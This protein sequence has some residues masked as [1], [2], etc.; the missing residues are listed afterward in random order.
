MCALTSL[1]LGLGLTTTACYIFLAILVGPALEKL[2]LNKMAVHMFIFYWGMLSSITPPVAIA[3][4]TAAGI[5]KT[6]LWETGI[7]AVRIALILF[8]IPFVFVYN[9]GLLGLG[10]P[11]QIVIVFCTTAAGATAL[12][13]AIIGYWRAHVPLWLRFFFAA[14]AI[15]LIIPETITDIIGV[16]GLILGLFIQS[17]R[18]RAVS[19]KTSG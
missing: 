16:A 2:G 7:E 19:P 3:S 9:P 1:I 14:V 6:G 13:I 17:R 10:P 5:A 18:V 11:L 15:C 4:Y 8:L 12:G